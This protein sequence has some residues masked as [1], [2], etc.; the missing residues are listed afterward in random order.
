MITIT[1]PPRYLTVQDQGRKHSRSTGV[2]R[3]GA[4]DSFAL[5]ATNLLVGNTETAAALEWALGGGALRFEA[6]CV[7]ALG[8]A[9]AV[10]TLAGESIV[11]FTTL[12][13]RAGDELAIE[14][15]S[16]GRFLYIAFR[17]GIDVPLVLHSRSTYLPGRFGGCEGRLLRK[18]ETLAL[19][20][21]AS[22][23]PSQRFRPPETLIPKYGNVAVRITRGPQASAF[24]ENEWATL[25]KG[26]YKISTS[27][28]RTGYR[29][30]GPSLTNAV[31]TLAS[32]ASCQGAIQIPGNGK[33]IALMADAPT[34]GGYP[35]IAVVAE[36]D[37][38]LL[39]QRSPGEDVRFELV[40]IE[41]SQR[42][43]KQRASDLQTIGELATAAAGRR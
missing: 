17:G 34:V 12:H 35:K 15:I 19:N 30:D 42:A 28:D 26:E 9:T 11:P 27:S 38:P 33:P 20:P 5:A 36:A 13:A 21:A 16:G 31:P 43:L 25:L 6:D 40:T 37:L 39:A 22:V 14:R 18:G 4:M 3:G 1:L 41:E 23:A 2:P 32:E 10:A 7:F 24:D 8:G 29:L